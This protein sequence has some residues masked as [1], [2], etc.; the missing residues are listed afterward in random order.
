MNVNSDGSLALHVC[1]L[2]PEH[3]GVPEA[4]LQDFHFSSE[5]QIAAAY[6]NRAGYRVCFVRA[7][8]KAVEASHVGGR[9]LPRRKLKKNWWPMAIRKDSPQLASGGSK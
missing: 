9:Y 2:N 7:G 1:D 6:A 4:E 3:R 8:S 5:A